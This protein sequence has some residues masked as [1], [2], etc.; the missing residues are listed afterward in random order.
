MNRRTENRATRQLSGT[1]AAALSYEPGRM[2]APKV[3][4]V[5]SS[6][7]AAEMIRLAR[8]LAIPIQPQEQLA[9]KLVAVGDGKTVPPELY[10]EVAAVL[11]DLVEF[12]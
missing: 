4:A 12:R 10:D 6:E 1:I 7:T 8:R 11:A 9:E 5:G 2:V 3:V